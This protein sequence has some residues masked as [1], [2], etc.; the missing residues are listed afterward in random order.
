MALSARLGIASLLLSFGSIVSLI[1]RWV[2][3]VSLVLAVFSFVLGILAA[4][5]GSKLWFA[6]PGAVITVGAI[7]L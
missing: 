6:V 4:H 2:P 3:P 7:L 1:W 5:R